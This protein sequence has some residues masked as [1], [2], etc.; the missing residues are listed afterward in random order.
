MTASLIF[1]VLLFAVFWMLLIRPQR[2]RAAEQQQLVARLEVG[3]EVVTAG[4]IIGEIERLDDDEVLLRIAPK[5]TVRVAR[6][7]VAGVLSDGDDE[8]EEEEEAASE[9]ER[10]S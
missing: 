2:R 7:A 3:D 1:L 9:P 5:T 4:G 8:A 10:E 6:R